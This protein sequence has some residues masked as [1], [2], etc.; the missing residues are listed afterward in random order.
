MPLQPCC[1]PHSA[2][3]IA[4]HT[5]W[6]CAAEALQALYMP[7]QVCPSSSDV[8]SVIS[9]DMWVAGGGPQLAAAHMMPEQEAACAALCLQGQGAGR[10]DLGIQE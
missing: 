1:L 2:A 4:V 5:L 10:V 6:A 8:Y 3:R 9:F 7:A